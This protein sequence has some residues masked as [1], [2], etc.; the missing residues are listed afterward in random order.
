MEKVLHNQ[1]IQVPPN[2]ASSFG[3]D[4]EWDI[5]T[6]TVINVTPKDGIIFGD[7]YYQ[8]VGLMVRRPYNKEAWTAFNVTLERYVKRFEKLKNKKSKR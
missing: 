5:F 3:K 7:V 1:V 6:G 8:N 4:N 2:M